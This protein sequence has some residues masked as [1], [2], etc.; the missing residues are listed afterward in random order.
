[1]PK[2]TQVLQLRL[3]PGLYQALAAEVQAR[4]ARGQAASLNAVAIEWLQQG[5]PRPAKKIFPAP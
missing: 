2:T 4:K 1:M 5:Q 3:P